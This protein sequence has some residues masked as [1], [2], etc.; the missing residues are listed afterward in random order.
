MDRLKVLKFI[1]EI[2][3][4]SFMELK[5]LLKIEQHDTKLKLINLELTRRLYAC[6]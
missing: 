3:N 4:K 2:K 6:N 1:N 5:D